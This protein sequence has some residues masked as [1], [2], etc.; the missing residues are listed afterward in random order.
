MT[1]NCKTS[2]LIS[3][4]PSSTTNAREVLNVSKRC[5]YKLDLALSSAE[6]ATPERLISQF[7]AEK[8]HYRNEF[9]QIT[10]MHLLA[11]A[12]IEKIADIPQWHRMEVSSK[13][14]SCS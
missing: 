5:Q 11:D 10:Q 4:L 3:I 12:E 8:H 13:K 14:S 7:S 1:P 9:L 6:G 2:I